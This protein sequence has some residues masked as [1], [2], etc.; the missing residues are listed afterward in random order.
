[1]TV[2]H[3]RSLRYGPHFFH[4]A[5]PSWSSCRRACSAADSLV[6]FGM[7]HSSFEMGRS[8]QP[9]LAGLSIDKLLIDRT[10][11]RVASAAL[12]SQNTNTS[13]SRRSSSNSPRGLYGELVGSALVGTAGAGACCSSRGAAR[14]A[15]EE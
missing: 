10:A 8:I 5:R 9:E 3:C 11:G 15:A 1:R 7:A 13:C 2:P 6:W 12:F 14:A 4:A